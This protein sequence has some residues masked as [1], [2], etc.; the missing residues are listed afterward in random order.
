MSLNLR[1]DVDNVALDSRALS[2]PH[3]DIPASAERRFCGAFPEPEPWPVTAVFLTHDTLVSID[4]TCG[5]DASLF[6]N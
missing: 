5:L 1:N 3:I 4:L 6:D 2:Q